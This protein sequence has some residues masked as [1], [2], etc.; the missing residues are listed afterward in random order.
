MCS[1]R[2]RPQTATPFVLLAGSVLL[3]SG[4]PRPSWSGTEAARTHIA[5]DNTSDRIRATAIL[6]NSI[7]REPDEADLK[8]LIDRLEDTDAAVRLHAITALAQVAGG[9]MGYEAA[10]PLAERHRAVRRWRSWF[11]ARAEGGS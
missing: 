11:A 1:A 3:L 5:S 10:A 7:T 2:T 8:R 9:R 4:C 6:G